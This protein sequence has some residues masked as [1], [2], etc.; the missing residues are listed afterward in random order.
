M[1]RLTSLQLVKAREAERKTA[2]AEGKM[3]D[4]AVPRRLDEAITMVG[5]C[6]DMCPRFERYRR[7]REN[8]LDKWE[9]IPGTKR[10][11]HKRAVKIYER[12]AGD[13]TLPSDLRPP[14]VLKKTL[15][16]LFHAL[17]VKEGFT[18]TYD[19]IRDR[20][21]AVR[22]DFTMQHE[23]GPLA[24]ECHDRCAR[25]HILAL[26]LERDNPRFSVA[27]EEQ[28]LMNTLQSLKEFYEDQRGAYEAPTELE[29][30]VYHRLIHIRD[31][32]E[33][34]EDVPEWITSHPVFQ[35]TTQ[36]RLHVQAK[37]API[38]KTSRL[39]VDASGMEI[40]GKLAAVLR[41]QGDTVMIYLVACI[42]ERLFGKDT[43]DDIETIR[44]DLT[45]PDIIDGISR[46]SAVRAVVSVPNPSQ[47]VPGPSGNTSKNIEQVNATKIG[48]T[49]SPFAAAATSFAAP[50][51]AT[52]PVKSAFGNLASKPNPFGSSSVFGTTSAFG[53]AGSANA[54]SQS[55]ANTT[56]SAFAGFAN[57][58]A[59]FPGT[60]NLMAVPSALPLPIPHHSILRLRH[61]PR[62]SRHQHLS[63]LLPQPLRP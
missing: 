44:G 57:G 14:P 29:M 43:I 25:F 62:P 33:R 49:A 39:V 1:E 19:F 20:S 56:K 24:I 5:T 47:P 38:T 18:Q 22:S 4:P 55:H 16:Y 32:K 6:M 51:N 36:F 45:I 23:H 48:P 37:S 2:I 7:E 60:T 11:A 8:N 41:E 63:C 42:L 28:Q 34:R 58:N 59:T 54:T 3:D 13:K 21:R 40:F 30:R 52:Q 17:L 27:L 12:A 9:V 10:V 46:P 35:Y 15:N 50:A 61:L 53:A 31:Q 26:H